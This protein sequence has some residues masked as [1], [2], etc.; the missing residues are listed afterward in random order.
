MT[1]K[2]LINATQSEEIRVAIVNDNVLVDLDIE[3]SHRIQKK[4][5]VYKAR[6]SRIE[7]SLNAVFV[8]YGA[9]RHGFLP[10]KE[11]APGYAD[12]DGKVTIRDG[13]EIIIQIEKEERGT[14]G[15]AVTTFITL[16]GCYLVLMPNSHR[17]GGVSRRIEGD[18]R[19]QLKELLEGLTI[20]DNMSVIARTACL[21]RT[22]E[23]LQ[24]D[25]DSL[26]KL[27]NTIQEE[28][29]KNKAPFLIYQESDV[30]M[31]SV[32]DYLRQDIEEIV[33][34]ERKTYE[35]VLELVRNL[36]PDFTDRV[37][38]YHN[39]IG[40]FTFSR[41]E[42]QIETAY[43]REVK[44]PSGGAIVIDHTEALTSI[45]INSSRATKGGDIEET[46]FVTN[47]EAAREVARQLKLRDLGG[48]IVIDFIDMENQK[49]QRLIEDELTEAVKSDR[50]RIQVSK[51]SR[52]GLLEMS[53]QRLRPSLEESSGMMCP[54]CSGQGTIRGV[55]SLSLSII[56][57]IQ[58]EAMR[59]DTL[60]VHVQLPISVATFILN[61]KR[62]VI[63]Q[64]EAQNK[65]RVVLIPNP[66]LET[67]HYTLSKVTQSTDEVVP[68][69]SMQVPLATESYTTTQVKL[70]EVEQ[71]A[72]RS[73]NIAA[74]PT[75]PSLFK[76]IFGPLGSKIQEAFTAKPETEKKEKFNPKNKA[77]YNNRRGGSGG[78][79]YRQN[80]Q[81]N[82]RGGRGRDNERN[83]DND[84][85]NDRNRD[86]R[87]NRDN[88][89]R[90]GGGQQGQ[91]GDRRRQDG[92][93][94]PY[95]NRPQGGSHNRSH[96]NEDRNREQQAA[97]KPVISEFSI[98]KPIT[99]APITAP[100]REISSQ[101]R[102]LV[103]DLSNTNS[104]QVQ[105]IQSNTLMPS[106]L[107]R[108]EVVEKTSFSAEQVRE[109]LRRQ[110]EQGGERVETKAPASQA[111]VNL[112]KDVV[113]L[114]KKTDGSNN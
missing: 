1:K 14:K 20:P 96:S 2:I 81:R 107:Q 5:N 54:R 33:V 23:E 66:N 31:R 94:R 112:Q 77:S 56:R 4:A 34:D 76:R 67:P 15:A 40:L 25:L 26:L 21:G 35:R 110:H 88:D 17:S 100:Q 9:E 3:A 38:F 41:I 58:E 69:Y 24:W 11:L 19:Q 16:A 68:S 84:Q 46:A 53:R 61:E 87:S 36:R 91:G 85:R 72:I 86:E 102:S 92:Q 71:P 106:K 37:R 101:V 93:G 30:I 105:S 13:D 109:N 55:E 111:N 95:N 78:R 75:A 44:L 12:R 32:R 89:R 50:A 83:R 99:S 97:A 90:R 113:D 79:N 59:A 104:N 47:L 65:I 27:W 28:N 48:L 8:D 49:N 74:A 45:D 73:L 63:S 103:G 62:N 18:D 57:L 52:F 39:D 70:K 108:E 43:Q 60:E 64:I 7:P 98:E 51:I 22:Q 42:S 29:Q 114:S 82:D 80:N 6:V 10:I